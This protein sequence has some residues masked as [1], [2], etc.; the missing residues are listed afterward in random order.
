M[1]GASILLGLRET[2]WMMDCLIEVSNADRQKSDENCPLLCVQSY[3]CVQSF[4]LKLIRPKQ[5]VVY[6]KL[7]SWPGSRIC[8]NAGLLQML[9]ILEL[10]FNVSCLHHNK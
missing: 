9:C 8:L 5:A 10:C 1:D 3:Y 2:G 6:N 7:T 4:L